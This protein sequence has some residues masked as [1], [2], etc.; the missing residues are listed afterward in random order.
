MTNDVMD[1]PAELDLTDDVDATDAATLA[2]SADAPDPVADATPDTDAAPTPDV[3]AD[4]TPAAATPTPAPVAEPFVV[5]GANTR[6]YEIPGVTFDPTTKALQIADERAFQRVQTLL[7]NGREYETAGR[8]QLQQA[9][10]QIDSVRAE[11][12]ENETKAAFYVD[13]WQQMMTM[14]VDE[15]AQML[16]EAR[17]QWPL[18][19]AKAE[20]AWTQQ[21]MTQQQQAA[22]GPAPDVEMIVEEA[23]TGVQQLVPDVLGDQPW[24]TPETRE[25]VV[26]WMSDVKRLDQFVMRATTDIPARNV[27]K[28][29][30]I[31][32]WDEATR[33]V[34]EY[35]TPYVD[36]H[37]ARQQDAHRLTATSSVAANNAKT[38][39]AAQKQRPTASNTP[40]ASPAPAKT[41]SR[42]LDDDWASIRAGMRR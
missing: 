37:A 12:S 9:Q 39:A 17:T 7:A 2:E 26:A 25:R 20:Q 10:R 24:V 34:Q 16:S 6:P 27:R 30:Y 42:E 28:G 5:Q 22:E 14:P 8:K 13:Q 19:Q 29:Q 4:A 3:A 40:V 31:A 18:L 41:L 11:K 21:L 32:D 1:L 35:V 33:M 23:R 15:L 38:L 36:A